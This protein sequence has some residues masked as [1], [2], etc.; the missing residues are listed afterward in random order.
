MLFIIIIITII[1]AEPNRITDY[2]NTF[3][4]IIKTILLY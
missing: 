3:F 2:I 4:I 1:F